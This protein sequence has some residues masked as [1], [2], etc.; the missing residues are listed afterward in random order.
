VP[1][2][3][4]WGESACRLLERIRPV[5]PRA[6]WTRPESW[7]LTLKFLGEIAAPAAD[8]FASIVERSVT[9]CAAGDLTCS[10]A[11]MFPPHGRARVLGVGFRSG[12]C[13]EM[14]GNLAGVAESAARAFGMAAETHRFRPHVTLAR[15]R[16][17]WS[18]G[19][20][21]TFRQ[22]IEGWEFPSWPVRRC[23]LYQSRLEPAGAVHTPL[24]V[25]RLG[26]RAPEASA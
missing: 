23:V 26:D 7:H 8:Q 21:E 24:Y 2:D 6:G 12:A 20:L 18:S 1:A 16:E 13:A 22:E 9:A 4:H 3:A 15:L 11:V 14:L 25:W 19:A 10:G 5:L 17:P